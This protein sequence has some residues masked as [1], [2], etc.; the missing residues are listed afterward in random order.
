MAISKFLSGDF[1]KKWAC[2]GGLGVLYFCGYLQI[3]L[4]LLIFVRMSPLVTFLDH[5]VDTI[6][7]GKKVKKNKWTR[8]PWSIFWQKK[9]TTKFHLF[10]NRS[11]IRLIWW[12]DFRL[13]SMIFPL[14][15][16]K[17][18]KFSLV[19]NFWCLRL[20]ISIK[21][22]FFWRSYWYWNSIF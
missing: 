20:K 1:G 9:K 16:L 21:I 22:W 17:W 10:V 8:H 18:G 12:C 5:W 15:F 4:V 3:A 2:E 7:P 6:T 13:D 11:L 14:Y 19:R